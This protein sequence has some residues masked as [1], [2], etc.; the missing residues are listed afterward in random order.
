MMAKVIP[1]RHQRLSPQAIGEDVSHAH[2]KR[3]CAA[4]SVVEGLLTDGLRK[5]VHFDR[6][7]GESPIADGRGRSLRRLSHDSRGTVDREINARLENT[8]S[9][10][11]HDRHHRL[12]HHGSIS[13]HAGLSLPA[14]E[15]RR[16]AA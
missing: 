5:G 8:G 10:H 13:H 3:R 4:S 14:D 7:D 11:R 1:D 12:G 16:G 2:C 15:F 6:A 9:N